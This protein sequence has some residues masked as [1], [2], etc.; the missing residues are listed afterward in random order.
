MT[1]YLFAELLGHYHPSFPGAL[2]PGVFERGRQDRGG[3]GLGVG[4][5]GLLNGH[6]FR[7]EPGPRDLIQ[8]GQGGGGEFKVADF[9]ASFGSR[10]AH[11]VS[12]LTRHTTRQQAKSLH[13]YTT[14]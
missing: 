9:P 12:C 3:G 1:L 14:G 7:P 2:A 6:R 10:V 11:V 8:R 4:N 5:Q 13:P